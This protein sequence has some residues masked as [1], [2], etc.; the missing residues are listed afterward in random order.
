[1]RF[2]NISMNVWL[3][4]T[5]ELQTYLIIKEDANTVKPHVHP[6]LPKSFLE[7][8]PVYGNFFREKNFPKECCIM[9][10]IGFS[11]FFIAT[12]QFQIFSAK[13]IMM[14][15]VVRNSAKSQLMVKFFKFLPKTEVAAHRCSIKEL[16]WR[17][18]KNSQQSIYANFI[19]KK[20]PVQTFSCEFCQIFHCSF[21]AEHLLDTAST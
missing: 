18:L 15:K 21:F 17:V 3:I 2:M 16:F 14:I 13:L 1:M 6:R 4:S 12:P 8:L 20:S 5:C 9:L 7:V 10:L 19:F 11:D